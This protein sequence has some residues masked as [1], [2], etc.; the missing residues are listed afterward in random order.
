MPLPSSAGENHP[1]FRLAVFAR[2]VPAG[3][4]VVR[5][6]L[7]RQP[8]VRI[9]EFKQQ[10]ELRSPHVAAEEF[11]VSFAHQ[12][13]Q[14]PARIFAPRDD[15]LIGPVVADLPAFRVVVFRADR[16]AEHGSQSP[17]AP[18]DA[19]QQ[20]CES[21]WLHDFVGRRSVCVQPV[22]VI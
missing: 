18:A 15:R 13:F 5:M 8:V 20:R 16:F 22:K 2:I 6:D 19:L 3:L 14:H 17:P 1:R 21:K 12:T 9:E 7:Q 11:L 4:L 10:R